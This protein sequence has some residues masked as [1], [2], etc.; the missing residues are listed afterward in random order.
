M[1]DNKVC[2]LVC[3]RLSHDIIGNIGA[4]ANAVELLEEGDGLEALA[5]AVD[6]R[7]P[8]ARTLVV[9]EIE[10]GGDR[11]HAKPVQMVLLD[12]EEGVG[13]EEGTHLGASVI[14]HTGAPFLMLALSR[15]SIF[16][17]RC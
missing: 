5:S 15:V 10:H 12:P 9:I 17:A 8:L 4:V 3:T 7:H 6:V 13:D 2:E 1:S 16:I 14:E 11:V